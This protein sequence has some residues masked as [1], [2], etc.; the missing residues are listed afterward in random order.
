[1]T[2]IIDINS[3]RLTDEEIDQ[4]VQRIKRRGDA[5]ARELEKLLES[6]SKEKTASVTASRITNKSRIS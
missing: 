2:G 4:H 3:S 5:T 1:L 6:V